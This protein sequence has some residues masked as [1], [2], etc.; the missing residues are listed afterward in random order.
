MRTGGTGSAVLSREGTCWDLV[1]QIASTLLVV[2]MASNLAFEPND[3][4]KRDERESGAMGHAGHEG[5]DSF[6]FFQAPVMIRDGARR[7]TCVHLR[8]S[9]LYVS[10]RV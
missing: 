4:M 8:V 7:T 5:K 3:R 10:C 6:R 1:A 2:A 9:R